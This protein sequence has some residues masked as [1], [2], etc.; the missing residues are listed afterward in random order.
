MKISNA[1]PKL[2]CGL[3]LAAFGTSASA[4]LISSATNNPYVFSWSSLGGGYTLTGS[5]SMSL[6]GFNTNS[7]T[8]SVKLTNDTVAGGSPSGKD[9]RLSQFGFGI[10]PNATGVT[11]SD[12]ADKGIVG[13]ALDT[14]PS[15][16]LIEVCGYGGNNC[17]GGGNEGIYGNGGSDTFS[18][19]LAGTWGDSVNIAPLG[20]KYQTNNG[21]FE[22]Y[23]STSSTGGPPTGNVPEPDTLALLGIGILGACLYRRRL[24]KTH[25]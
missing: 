21:S 22:F 9:A 8:L 1:I 12:A 11:F 19:I 2:M 13:A 18:I 5:G 17:S 10:D 15:L 20:Y 25:S 6:S 14:I 23:S 3:L 24:H 7:L 16:S 4:V